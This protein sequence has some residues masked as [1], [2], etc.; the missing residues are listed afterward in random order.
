M[1]LTNHCLYHK[2]TSADD[3]ISS[4][5]GNICR[6]TG[7]KSLER[8]AHSISKLLNG[9]NGVSSIQFAVENR[10]VPAYFL[11]IP[12]R[13]QNIT[14]PADKQKSVTTNLHDIV[15]GGTDVYVQKAEDLV[16]ENTFSVFDLNDLKII[17]EVNGQ[18]E[19]G[20]SVTVT[21][22]W[23]SPLMNEIF[24]NLSEHL[25]LI[26]S[27]PIRNMATIGGNIV[28]ASPIGDMTIWFLAMDATVILRNDKTREIGL[29]DFYQGYKKLAKSADEIVEKI[30]FKKPD[31]KS[32]FNFEKV[33]K[34]TTLDIATVNTAVY[35]EVNNGVISAAHISAG[36]VAP[37]PLYLKNLSSC[38]INKNI[39]FDE[40]SV[41]ELDFILQSEIAPLSDVRGSEDY[42]RM[43]LRQLFHAHIIEFQNRT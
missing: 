17:R 10:I 21:E 32:F 13:L 5:D 31:K 33:S 29:R 16:H 34:R 27:T 25:N 35:L 22:L 38:L 26:S 41:E 15:G 4:M 37:I 14:E 23:E 11:N 9:K 1:S 7:Y 40:E 24:P 36:G 2:S 6:C 20:A 43:L 3:A 19:I 39:P 8:A 42:K 12:A 28:N 18:I 30:R